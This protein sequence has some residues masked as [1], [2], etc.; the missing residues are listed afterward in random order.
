MDHIIDLRKKRKKCVEDARAILKKAEA[1]KRD[2]NAEEQESWD[3]AFGEAESLKGQ[4][5]RE[6]RQREAEKSLERSADPD[7]PK[8]E[9]GEGEGG[10]DPKREQRGRRGSTEYRAVFQRFVNGGLRSLGPEEYRAI[11]V[12][13]DIKAGYMVADEQFTTDLI[14][15]IDDAVYVRQLANTMQLS[16]A[17]SLGAASLDA[18]PADSDWTAE[19]QSVSE[20]TTLAVGKRNLEPHLCSKLIKVSE[21]LLR[22]SGGRALALV[23]GRLAYK[24]GVTHE[25]AFLTGSGA[26]QPL[27]L[28]TASSNGISTSRDVSTGNTTTEIKPDNLKRCKYTLKQGY[29]ARSRWLFHRD[30]I[31]AVARL[32]DGQGRFLW[33]DSIRLGEPDRLLNIPVL[34]SEYVP[35]TFTTG[36]YVGLLGDISYYWIVDALDMQVQRLDELYAATN[37]VGF[38]GRMETDGMPVLEEA[39]VRVTLA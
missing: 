34:E 15:G 25:K 20:D 35:N 29:R 31:S 5:D 21:K 22:M 3:K 26:M 9:P 8:P 13:D 2:L 7:P 19:I 30:G 37:Q 27:G 32:K 39:F 6:E 24:F 17:K 23:N 38:I 12:D 11:Q 14:K 33:E 4:I 16:T 10:G 18:D 36:L 28:F 1:E